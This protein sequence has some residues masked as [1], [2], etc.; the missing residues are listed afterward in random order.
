M[1]YNSNIFWSYVKHRKQDSSRISPLKKSDGLLYSAAP[2]QA[3]ILNKQFHYPVYTRED[4]GNIQSQGPS[5]HKSRAK[6][7]VSTDGVRK[8]LRGFNIYKATGPD[9]IP[10]MLLHDFPGTDLVCHL[11]EATRQPNDLVCHLPEATRQTNDLRRVQRGCHRTG[12]QKRRPI[13]DIRPVSLT[14]V[15]CKVFEHVIHSQIMDHFDRLKI[16]TDKQHSLRSRR[17]CEMK[18]IVTTDSIAKSPAH[19][20]QVDIILLD[21]SKAFDTVPNKLLLH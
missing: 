6:I 3:D 13:P 11:P 15:S 1:K 9:Q 16:H 17:S 18:L 2:T 19:E 12:F 21:F 14:S 5:P 20:E 10:K 7:T 8:L 4:N